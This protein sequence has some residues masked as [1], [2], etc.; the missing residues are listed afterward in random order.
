MSNPIQ[1]VTP[2]DHRTLVY[3]GE[4]AADGRWTDGVLRTE[5]DDVSF[6]VEDGIP[7]FCPDGA[8]L[9]DNKEK[10]NED[11]RRAGVDDPDMLIERNWGNRVRSDS[12][13]RN[14]DLFCRAL[15]TG[16]PILE[17]AVGPGGGMA[18]MLLE[19]DPQASI[20]MNDFGLWPL[21]E[22]Q[23]LARRTGCW[24]NVRFAQFDATRMP[25]ASGSVSAVLSWGGVS[26]IYQRDQ[27]LR[28]VLRIL[29]PGGTLF[30]VDPQ[31]RIQVT[32]HSL[33]GALDAFR[34]AFPSEGME[35][36]ELLAEIGFD[37]VNVS[38]ES[39]RPIIPGE[40]G[41][42]DFAEKYKVDVKLQFYRIE[43]VK[44]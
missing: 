25:I 34:A 2:D 24:P 9:W 42:A 11:L 30:G 38:D 12:F 7:R 3:E 18:P 4:T 13:G 17:V 39:E 8:S 29:R 28:E 31:S 33:P 43:A 14:K 15:E 1:F 36:P 35:Y 27:A 44:P 32:A 37:P 6:P 41:L 23:R 19:L 20:M 40:G 10:R 21:R 22:W 26:N 16:G 5:K